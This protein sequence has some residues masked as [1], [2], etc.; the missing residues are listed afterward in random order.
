MHGR[1]AARWLRRPAS[2]AVASSCRSPRAERS[3]GPAQNNSLRLAAFKQVLRVRNVASQATLGRKTVDRGRLCF[4]LAASRP[5]TALRGRPSGATGQ[6]RCWGEAV[7]A[8]VMRGVAA[9]HEASGPTR[10][11]PPMMMRS[12]AWAGCGANKAQALAAGDPATQHGFS[13]AT[14]SC[15]RKLFDR[16]VAQGVFSRGSRGL[17]AQGIRVE[18]QSTEAE[19]RSHRAAARPCTVLPRA[20]PE[21][22]E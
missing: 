10:G 19:R 22:K 20:A 16:S 13:R 21:H 9:G 1:A 12:C 6:A 2:L 7:E 8:A 4:I 18:V 14:V 3:G 15:S 11:S 5:C 17:P